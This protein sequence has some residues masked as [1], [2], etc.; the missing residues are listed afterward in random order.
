MSDKTGLAFIPLYS[1]AHP[2]T[3]SVSYQSKTAV[4]PLLNPFT[5]DESERFARRGMTSLRIVVTMN[6]RAV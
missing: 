5:E 3:A 4:D 2:P 6:V 1:P